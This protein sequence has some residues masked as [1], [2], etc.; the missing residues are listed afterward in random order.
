MSQSP[1]TPDS[2]IS[3]CSDEIDPMGGSSIPEGIEA[4]QTFVDGETV[5]Q[6]NPPQPVEATTNFLVQQTGGKILIDD[7]IYLIIS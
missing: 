2:H 5:W 6:T 7:K 3:T 1:C 4:V